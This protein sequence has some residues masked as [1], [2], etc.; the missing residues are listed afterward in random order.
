MGSCWWETGLQQSKFDI[1][2]V[3]KGDEFM[4]KRRN[5]LK[6]SIVAGAGVTIFPSIIPNS[7]F[8]KPGP[9]D[10]INI[11]QIGCG[12]IAITHDMPLVI[13]HD[14]VRMVAVAD[15]D[16]KRANNAK[17]WIEDWYFTNTKKNEVD[18]KVYQDYR[19]MLQDKSIDAV[20]IST[21]DHWHAQPA[22]EAVLSGKDVYLQ[23][24][25]ALTIEEGRQMSD[26][27][28][29]T[30]QI[31]QIGSQ[32]RSLDP[33]PQFHRAVE[34]VRNGRIGGIKH[35]EVGLYADPAGGKESVMPVPENL[36]Y[37]MWL[38]STPY[39]YYTEER[40]HPQNDLSRPG[41]LR[42]EQF[43][44][45]MITGWGAHH[46]DTAQWGL[47]MEYSAPV[48][49]EG[50]AVFPESGLWDVHGKFRVQAKYANGITMDIR[51][52]F[53]NGVKFIGSKGW[54]FV[55][56]GPVKVT[57]S[58][59]GAED[60][61]LKAIDASDPK[62]LESK[63]GENE[64]QLYKSP[65]QHLNWLE[66]IR[67]R[68]QPIAPAEIAHRSTSVCLLSYISMKLPRKLYWNPQAERFINDDEANSMLSRPQRFPYGTNYIRF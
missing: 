50:E 24:P 25:A 4:L 56:R 31:F 65:E 2:K 17:K 59:P 16:I 37:E 40:V 64:V 47:D 58:D 52:D 28:H 60:V 41:W 19:D 44:A 46:L 49:F 22:I 9:N 45:G 30:G 21:P 68:K 1:A 23:K 42:C 18:V 6:N 26:A 15:V 48:E 67:S 43:G 55:S 57:A 54:I 8:A 33:W 11:A 29:R 53:P 39:V 34:L 20:I 14:F 27:A 38:G 63:I 61:E 62:I 5:F 3:S 36:N 32:Q 13:K 7:V 12:R 35:V 10:K 66:C 51:D